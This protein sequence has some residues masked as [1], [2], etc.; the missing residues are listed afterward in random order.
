MQVV[1]D[2]HAGRGS[3]ARPLS[4]AETVAVIRDQQELWKP[5]LAKV[6]EEMKK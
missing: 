3:F 4:A 5:A 2:R 6:A 1:K